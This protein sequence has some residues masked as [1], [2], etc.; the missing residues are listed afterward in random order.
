MAAEALRGGQR[1]AGDGRAPRG[2]EFG[3]AILVRQADARL[4]AR[5]AEVKAH[6]PVAVAVGVDASVSA[7]SAFYKTTFIFGFVR[8]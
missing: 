6:P 5:R 7:V 1:L 2:L 3:R 8:V 4:G